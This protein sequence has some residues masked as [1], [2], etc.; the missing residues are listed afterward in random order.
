MSTLAPHSRP[1]GWIGPPGIRKLSRQTVP[2][3]ITQAQLND[4]LPLTNSRHLF[5]FLSHKPTGFFR[6]NTVR[7]L[8]RDLR[9]LKIKVAFHNPGEKTRGNLMDALREKSNTSKWTNA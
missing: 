6:R 7:Y 2:N 8:H 3:R 5:Y 4:R 1:G 9:G